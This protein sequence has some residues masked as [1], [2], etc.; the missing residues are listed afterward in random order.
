LVENL[1]NYRLLI[2]S[3]RARVR[4]V[5]QTIVTHWPRAR[6]WLE[7]E[8]A[9]LHSSRTLG[10][11]AEDWEERWDKDIGVRELA[12]Q[13]HIDDA[14]R[15]LRSWSDVFAPGDG[16][17]PQLDD[18]RL[19][20]F[21]IA[22]IASADD[23]SRLAVGSDHEATH[24]LTAVQYGELSLAKRYL[25]LAPD[26][27]RTQR[28]SKG[29]Q[30]VIFA[31]WSRK[32]AMLDLVLKHGGDPGAV[33]DIG[34]QAIHFAAQQGDAAIFD[35]LVRAGINPRAPGA[36]G[37]TTLHVVASNDD[38][39]M[40]RHLLTSHAMDVNTKDQ[41][42]GSALHAACRSNTTAVVEVLLEQERIQ[43][44]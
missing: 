41:A 8:K 4:L 21:A 13:Q 16:T 1:R 17:Q 37:R 34:W 27:A 42:G 18:R 14:G 38:V 28:S 25:E 15:L 40:L 30:S 33:N 7:Q 10:T 11:L 35:R 39:V 32:P 29:S 20:D 26:A 43:T 2:S 6:R 23:P 24:F 5:H 3:G 44:S 22:V 31:A 19:R 36:K 12:G 9:L